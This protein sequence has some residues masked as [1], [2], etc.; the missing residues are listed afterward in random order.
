MYISIIIPHYNDINRLIGLLDEL[1][2]QVLPKDKWEVFVINNCVEFPLELPLEFS[3]SY[4]LKIIEESIPGSYAARNKGIKEAKGDLLAFTDSDCL[5]EK[6]WLL[7]ALTHFS[8]DKEKKIGVLTGPIPLFFKDPS[9][10]SAAEIY[11]KYTGFTT[12]AYALDGKAVT[13]NWFSYSTVIDEFGGFDPNLKSNGDSKLSG[14]ISSKYLVSYQDDIIVFHPARYLIK[15]LSNKYNRLLGGTYTRNYKGK[16]IMFLGYLIKFIFRRYR[17]GFKK[18]VTVR[19]HE[20]I[21][22]I[23]VCHCINK[24]V[25]SEFFSIIRGNPT[26]R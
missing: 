4:Q 16:N 20:S 14:Q 26:T 13:A 17:F 5:P 15:E 10:L 12:K 19:L 3:V 23:K 24:S 9:N 22:I 25:F 1:E 6:H 2:N 7:N 11:E 21:K 18:L 8:N